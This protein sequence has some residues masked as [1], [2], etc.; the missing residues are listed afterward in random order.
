M[1]PHFSG[2][3]PTLSW[4]R[5]RLH[6]REPHGQKSPRSVADCCWYRRPARRTLGNDLCVMPVSLGFNI[7]GEV[8]EVVNDDN[9]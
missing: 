3:S 4:Q 2:A 8:G 5:R 1:Y 9:S 7:A 6:R